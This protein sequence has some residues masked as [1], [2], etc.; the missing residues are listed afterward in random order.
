[1]AKDTDL[2][3]IGAAA[4]AVGGVQKNSVHP[5]MGGDISSPAA[6]EADE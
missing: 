3:L 4:E 2:K 1:L 5:D 6:Y